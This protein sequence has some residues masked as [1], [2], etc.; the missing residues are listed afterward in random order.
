MWETLPI[1]ISVC[2]NLIEKIN[3]IEVKLD[4]INTTVANL[5]VLCIHI[6][7]YMYNDIVTKIVN[8]VNPKPPH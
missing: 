3:P 5:I 2:H 8:G 1:F 7:Q 4:G 6:V